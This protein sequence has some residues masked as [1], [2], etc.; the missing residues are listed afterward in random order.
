MLFLLFFTF[1]L[2][3]QQFRDSFE[4]LFLT[5][6]IDN[7]ENPNLYI[8]EK[9]KEY[10]S[11]HNK[12]RSL[13][14]NGR[15]IVFYCE[16]NLSGGIGDRLSGL[17]TVFAFA[18]LTQRALIIK[19]DDFS[20]LFDSVSINWKY[21]KIEHC[22]QSGVN[23]NFMGN[24]QNSMF[25]HIE[26]ITR[27]LGESRVVTIRSNKG[28]LYSL[29]K[30]KIYVKEFNN[31]GL[32]DNCSAFSIL[33]NL[34]LKPT[35]IVKET[36]K[37]LIGTD[38]KQTVI[39]ATHIRTGDNDLHNTRLLKV[40]QQQ[41]LNATLKCIEQTEKKILETFN[42]STRIKTKWLILIDNFHINDDFVQYSKK[43][44]KNPWKPTHIDI[45]LFNVSHKFSKEQYLQ[46]MINTHAEWLLLMLSDVIIVDHNSGFHRSAIYAGLDKHKLNWLNEFVIN[47]NTCKPYERKKL[48]EDL[49][50]EGTGFK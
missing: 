3:Q 29:F 50:T 16:P 20:V 28:R 22:L 40:G 23:Y 39:F 17:I 11:F 47:S 37:Q 21:E 15:F 12:Q 8:T 2:C 27:L 43:V 31:Y 18:L 35:K 25:Y 4:N 10:I 36:C 7:Y 48:C 13:C 30:S 49:T 9:F 46:D 19:I 14:E 42:N 6:R 44:I 41:K 26:N 33:L 5:D 45:G 38:D 34:L 24:L 1:T 32:Y